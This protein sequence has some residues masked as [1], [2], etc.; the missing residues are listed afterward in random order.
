MYVSNVYEHGRTA[1]WGGTV[2]LV[3]DA[4]HIVSN[5][6][7][8]VDLSAAL[9]A[10]ATLLESNYGWS[11]VSDNYWLDT[12]AFGM[13]FGPDSGDPYDAG[14]TEFALNLTSYCLEVGTTVA[15]ASC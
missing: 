13:E 9:A 6:T 12:V 2:W 10:V 14:P 7:V 3:P 1:P 5:G 8:S 4:Q 11:D 15:E